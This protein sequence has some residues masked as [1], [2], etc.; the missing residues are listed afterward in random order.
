MR[1]EMLCLPGC[2]LSSYMDNTKKATM[3]ATNISAP[4]ELFL[5]DAGAATVTRLGGQHGRRCSSWL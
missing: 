2:L 5:D 3:R 4:T 1:C